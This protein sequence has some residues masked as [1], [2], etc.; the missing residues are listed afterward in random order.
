MA[1]RLD[2]DVVRDDVDAAGNLVAD[3]VGEDRTDDGRHSTDIN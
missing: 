3:E 1:I 2:F